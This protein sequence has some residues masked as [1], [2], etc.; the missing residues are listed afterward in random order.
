MEKPS[1]SGEGW[2]EVNGQK[3]S[4]TLHTG[5]TGTFFHLRWLLRIQIRVNG[6]EIVILLHGDKHILPLNKSPK[7]PGGVAMLGK[8]LLERGRVRFFDGHE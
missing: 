6:K 8:D 4:C 3:P 2:G 7:R 1:P 5:R